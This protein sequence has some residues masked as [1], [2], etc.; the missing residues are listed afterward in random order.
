MPS[1]KEKKPTSD[2]LSIVE[3]QVEQFY[4]DQ[5][6]FYHHLIQ[7]PDL[8]VENLAHIEAGFRDFIPV[9]KIGINSQNLY[10]RGQSVERILD[11]SGKFVMLL[12][13]PAASGKSDIRSRLLLCKPEL[14][15]AYHSITTR[16]I[17]HI[18]PEEQNHLKITYMNIDGLPGLKDSEISSQ[19]IHVSDKAFD[20]LINFP[21]YKI[22]EVKERSSGFRYASSG[23]FIERALERTKLAIVTTIDLDGANAIKNYFKDSDIKVVTAHIQPSNISFLNF[24]NF[25]LKVRPEDEVL[26]LKGPGRATLAVKELFEGGTD[27][28]DLIAENPYYLKYDPQTGPYQT[29]G[30]IC[31]FAQFLKEKQI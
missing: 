7:L 5:V 11:I 8:S 4:P 3:N 2:I 10:I 16:P 27:E 29:V 23:Y 19:Y 22:I 20:N 15:T 28:I 25:M 26:G 9:S 1:D 31:E 13:G 24:V 21:D 30:A 6:D 14:F 17:Q 12:V 18:R